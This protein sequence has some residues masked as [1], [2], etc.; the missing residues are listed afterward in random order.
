[1]KKGHLVKGCKSPIVDGDGFLVIGER[2]AEYAND[3]TTNQVVFC[4]E[5]KQSCDCTM[6]LSSTRVKI[7]EVSSRW[8]QVPMGIF[9]SPYL[10]SSSKRIMDEDIL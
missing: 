6:K 3:F 9:F 8:T 4:V 5:T 10:I 1:M 2:F 7:Q